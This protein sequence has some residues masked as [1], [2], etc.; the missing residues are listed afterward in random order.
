MYKSNLEDRIK[1]DVTI[2]QLTWNKSLENL[3]ELLSTKM[4]GN[5]LSVNETR[6]VKNNP[7]FD[8]NSRMDKLESMFKQLMNDTKPRQEANCCRVCGKTNHKSSD[9][10]RN[11]TCFVCNKK[12]H[13]SK[14]CSQRNDN[15]GNGS[16]FK[17]DG[18]CYLNLKLESEHG[19]KI[20]LE[21]E[22]RRK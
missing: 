8:V 22:S 6:I 12:G 20:L 5:F 17:L 18:I 2:L 9:C 4:E 14:F 16:E 3:L 7:Q 1:M 11:K 13:I 21:Y 15:N 19:D 10:F